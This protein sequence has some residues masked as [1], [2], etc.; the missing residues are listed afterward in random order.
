LYQLIE[1]V[2]GFKLSDP[3][4][5]AG[6]L[7]LEANACILLSKHLSNF[8]LPSCALPPPCRWVYLYTHYLQEK[9]VNSI[10]ELYAFM[11]RA[12]TTLDLKVCMAD[13]TL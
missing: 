4:E 12:N 6:C 13:L 2:A 10:S 11:D 1:Q 3:L 8:A 7:D 5:D 9:V